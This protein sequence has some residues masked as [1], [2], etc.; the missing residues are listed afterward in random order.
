MMCDDVSCI[1][2]I[3][4][5]GHYRSAGGNS[6]NIHFACGLTCSYD[7]YHVWSSVRRC[8]AGVQGNAERAE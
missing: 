3:T 7:R 5:K 1:K 6:A 4:C 2:Y 8:C